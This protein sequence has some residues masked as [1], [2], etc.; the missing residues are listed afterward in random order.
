MC[1]AIQASELMSSTTVLHI[2]QE[3]I[4]EAMA[5]AAA[6]GIRRM[7]DAQCF[8]GSWK[9]MLKDCFGGVLWNSVKIVLLVDTILLIVFIIVSGKPWFQ[10]SYLVYVSKN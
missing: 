6:D 7:H 8:R 4:N 10:P 9:T 3:E 1:H 5:L 2:S